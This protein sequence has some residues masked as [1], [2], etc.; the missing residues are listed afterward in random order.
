M[1]W[2]ASL[3][4]YRSAAEVRRDLAARHPAFASPLSEVAIVGAA[5]E[6]RRLLALCAQHGIAVRAVVDDDPKKHGVHMGSYVIA[7]TSSLRGLDRAIPVVVASHRVLRA[8]ESLRGMGFTQ[9]ASFAVLQLLDPESFPPHIFYRGLIEDLLEQRDRYRALAARL[10]DDL[11][12]RVLDAAIGFRLTLDAELLRPI[13]EWDLYGPAGLLTYGD[14]EVYV[15]AGSYDGDTIRL[16]IERVHGRFARILAFEPDRATFAR[17]AAHFTTEPRV[18]PFNLGLHCTEAVLS[19]DDAGTRG[20]TLA[21]RGGSETSVVSLDQVV[22]GS[23]V[24]YIKMN[25][26]GAELDALRGAA[27]TITRWKPKLAVSAYHRPADLWRVPETIQDID[28]SYRL[29]VRQHD[30]GIIE[31][32]VYALP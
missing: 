8:T 14:D 7:A 17:L 16:F 29:Y 13:V 31:S 12:R 15:D 24:T 18:E 3:D 26:E 1:P 25:I 32:V 19:F 23:R 28:S 5:E 2:L 10:A 20:S 4:A 22:R 6:G 21:D 9:I 11:S 30:G 27:Q